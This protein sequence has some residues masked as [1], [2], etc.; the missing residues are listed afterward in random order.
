MKNNIIFCLVILVTIII[1]I[2]FFRVKEKY[3]TV[4]GAIGPYKAQFAHCLRQCDRSNP[5]NRLLGQAN[6]N[7]GKYCQYILTDFAKKGIPPQSIKIENNQTKCEKS[8]S[9]YYNDHNTFRKCVSLCSGEMEVEQ[10]C[11]ELW[12]PYS[13]L[14]V[15]KC[16]NACKAINGTN[17]NQN[18]WT[19]MMEK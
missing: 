16:V 12:C 9:R 11:R 15:K 7:C 19:W 2:F 4:L 6:I 1:I 18:S 10:W 14:P 3:G 17:N 5:N 13:H 8:C